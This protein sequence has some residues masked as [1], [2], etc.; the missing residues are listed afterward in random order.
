MTPIRTIVL[1]LVAL[2]APIAAQTGGGP[3]A[4]RWQAEVRELD[5]AM[6]DR[7]LTATAPRARWVAGEIERGDPIGQVDHLAE[8][9][10]QVPRERLYVGSLALACLEPV[11]PLPAPCDAMDRLADWATRDENNGLPVLLLAERAQARRDVASMIAQLE[12]ATAKPAFD[13][14][15][16]RGA[17]FL[18]EEVLALPQPGEPAAKAELAAG[19]GLSLGTQAVR[20]ID[21]LCREGGTGPEPARAACHAAGLALSAKGANWSLRQAGARLAERTAATAQA[22]EQARQ[23]GAELRRRAFACAEA[24]N[25]LVDALES[26]RRACAPAPWASG[27]F[28]SDATRNSV[29]W[30][31]AA[32]GRRRLR[33]RSQVAWTV[34]GA[35][36]QPAICHW[37][38]RCRSIR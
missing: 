24:G 32:P 9:R 3:A 4:S 12:E 17:L 34:D 7:A 27:R 5:A 18:W 22:Q 28:G 13:D 8:A 14:Y 36:T 19:Y 38:S 15:F 23:V 26:P 31:P 33:L 10:R 20:G 21:A 35:N 25:A 2:S 1:L 30:P 16:D 37:P 6:R 11:R 29:K